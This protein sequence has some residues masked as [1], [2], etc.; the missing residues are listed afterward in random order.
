MISY[1]AVVSK[2]KD[3]KIADFSFKGLSTDTKPTE[4][5]DGMT[6]KNGSSFLEIDTKDLKFY[7]ADGK[8][9]V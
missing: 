2:D 9:W 5:F 7:D 6:V 1:E 4:V 3:E 8:A